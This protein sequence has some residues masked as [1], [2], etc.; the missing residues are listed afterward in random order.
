MQKFIF[1]FI[2][3][4]A[5][6]SVFSQPFVQ[7]DG[8]NSFSEC[9]AIIAYDNYVLTGVGDKLFRSTDSGES[10]EE[11]SDNDFGTPFV[12]P[13]CF[14]LSDGVLI[15]GTNNGERVYRSVDNGANWDPVYEGLPMISGFPSAVPSYSCAL[16]GVFYMGG[17]NFI[18]KSEDLGLT[19]QEMD[20]SGICYG[21]NVAGGKVYCSPGGNPHVSEDDGDTWTAITAP[22]YGGILTAQTV[23]FAENNG[24]LFCSTVLSAG[25][26]LFKSM[27]DGA[28]WE[29][30]ANFSLGKHM[31]VID[32]Q[33]YLSSLEGLSRSADDGETWETILLGAATSYAGHFDHDDN[34]NLYYATNQGLKIYDLIND[35]GES[36]PFPI[37][38]VSSLTYAG[39]NMLAIADGVLQLSQDNGL[40]WS[41]LSG[42]FEPGLVIEAVV[43]DAGGAYVVGN[44]FGIPYYYVSD[45]FG[46]TFTLVTIDVNLALE[47]VLTFNPVVIASLGGLYVSDDNGQTFDPAVINDLDGQPLGTSPSFT[48]LEY[49][50]D[51]VFAASNS[52]VAYSSDNAATW[53]YAP[54]V[55]CYVATG[56]EDQII[57]VN[58]VGWPL[59]QVQT[60]ADGGATW[61]NFTEG[62]GAIS[63]QPE[64][65]WMSGNRVYC[66]LPSTNFENAGTFWSV[67]QGETSW[68]QETDLGIIPDTVISF[69]ENAEGDW[70]IGTKSASAWTLSEGGGTW[71]EQASTADLEF[72][73]NP[74]SHSVML[75]DQP[76]TGSIYSATG[77]RVMEFAKQTRLD[78]SG[79]VPG[80]YIIQTSQGVGRIIKE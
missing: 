54:S 55:S 75:G 68:T 24:V 42:Q 35:E 31:D 2:G 45:D 5:F 41:D 51:V 64:M 4:L 23:H 46:L 19:W 22:V 67:G 66:H 52:G 13:R 29:Q 69:A 9:F 20:I 3:I 58:N 10:F 80:V 50:G 25:G 49:T 34:G 62:M 12:S 53:T 6:S 65:V 72:F 38:T 71:V 74:T 17:T 61:T 7:L 40:T 16:N 26:G 37:A 70:V 36:L 48:G 30:C 57:A 18:R 15:M 78:V 60:S 27:D 8:P 21:F 14:A 32:G 28:T 1:A 77:Q 11:V 79:L 73:P 59:Y 44:L 63:F 39:S 43:A 47:D 33:V 56:W 76:L